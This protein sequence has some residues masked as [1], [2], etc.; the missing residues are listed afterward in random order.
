MSTTNHAEIQTPVHFSEPSYVLRI[1]YRNG[2][3]KHNIFNI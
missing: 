3:E 1:L 2:D